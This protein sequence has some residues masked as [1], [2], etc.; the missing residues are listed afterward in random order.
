MNRCESC[1]NQAPTV[2]KELGGKW[3]CEAC[4]PQRGD[5]HP[6]CFNC[7]A[8]L[9]LSEPVRWFID[10]T[11]VN[12]CAYVCKKCSGGV[13]KL[14]VHVYSEPLIVLRLSES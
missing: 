4:R 14:G 10:W 7:D 9:P 12:R 5:P 11:A 2:F 8:E 3:Q 13:M 6:R 1:G